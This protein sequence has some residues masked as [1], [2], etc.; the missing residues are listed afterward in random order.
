MLHP[1]GKSLDGVFNRGLFRRNS[2]DDC[3]I[4]RDSPAIGGHLGIIDVRAAE[5]GPEDVPSG[6]THSG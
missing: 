4:T 5:E 2:W 3:P 1:N 6:P